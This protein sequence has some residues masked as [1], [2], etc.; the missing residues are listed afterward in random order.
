MNLRP[1]QQRMVAAIRDAWGEHRAIVG[2]LPTGGGKTE[3]G[4]CII[5]HCASP[6]NR[7]LVLTERKVLNN[8]WPERMLRQGM[9]EF[10]VI[11]AENTRRIWAPTIVA[12]AQSV[13]SQVLK[14]GAGLPD[15]GLIVIDEAHIW[16]H[17]HDAVLAA[18]PNAK[19]LGLTATPLREGLGLRFSKVVVGATIRELIAEGYLVPGRYYAPSQTAV[20]EAL[21]SVEIRAG[22]YAP[23]ELS[24]AMRAKAIVG[25]VVG[26]WKQRGEDRQTIA[27]CV[28]KAHA[29]ML[30]GE[31]NAAGVSAAFIIDDTDDDERR[32]LFDAFERRAVRVL[33]SV[34]VLSIGFDS[35]IASCVI[36]ARPTMSLSLYVQ[37]G[38]RGLRPYP[39]KS[40]CM[41]LDHAGNVVR[42]GSLEDF[43]PPEDLSEVDK[44]TDK[45]KRGSPALHWVCRHC[46]AV[47][48]LADDVCAECGAA[49]YRSS[50]VVVL[51][52]QLH[53]I[54][55]EP[56]D[57]LPGPTL[58]HI[59]VFYRM[60][61]YY[62]DAKGL[63]R[64]WAFFATARRFKL[65]SRQAKRVIS[66]RW[67]ALEPITPDADACRWYRAD[68]QRAR[69]ARRYV[70][71]RHAA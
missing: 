12:T 10:G 25:D 29:E 31:F 17:T 9:S 4:I 7:V 49:R 58:D 50:S 5:R 32:R 43:Q 42:H 54:D 6:T 33:C 52:G 64:G 47:N 27:F 46:D 24:K 63:S 67:R 26:T 48:E 34:G 59:E 62:A 30:A 8:Q 51:D 23:G 21:R 65:D 28:D 36:M 22:D 3:V 35:P 41:F 70:E 19:V 2:S 60:S 14:R 53:R 15:F 71:D 40:D 13:A 55:H 39:G 69:I 37:Q 38:G 57:D 1:Y 16:H 45:K 18:M 56:G 20:E 44:T 66:Y 61:L 11:Q 68:Y